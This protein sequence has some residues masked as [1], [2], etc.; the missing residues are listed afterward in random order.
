MAQRTYL[1]GLWLAASKLYKYMSRWQNLAKPFMTVQQVACF[2]ATLTAVEE[3]VE[4][5][6]PAPPEV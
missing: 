2:D 6:K 1:I 4:A 3:C 5:F